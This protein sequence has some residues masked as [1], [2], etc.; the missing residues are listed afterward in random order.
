[1]ARAETKSLEA[2]ILHHRTVA[3]TSKIPTTPLGIE[4][5]IQVYRVPTTPLGIEKPI[6]VYRIPTTPETNTGLQ[7]TNHTPGDRT[8][9]IQVYRI[10]TTP[11]GIRTTNKPAIKAYRFT[12]NTTGTLKAKTDVMVSQLCLMCGST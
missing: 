4:Q 3:A 10:A 12:G 7:N 5:P 11:L 1:M 6:Q 8:S 2:D 9:Q